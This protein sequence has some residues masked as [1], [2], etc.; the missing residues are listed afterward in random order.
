MKFIENISDQ[1][2]ESREMMFGGAIIYT[3]NPDGKMKHKE[4]RETAAMSL[5]VHV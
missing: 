5:D 1:D 3:L 4:I 2:I